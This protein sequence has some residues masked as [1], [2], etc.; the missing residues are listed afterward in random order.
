MWPR[1]LLRMARWARRPPSM[2]RVVLGAAVIA[3]CLLLAAAE[4]AGW[5]PSGSGTPPLKMPAIRPLP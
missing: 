4:W 5:L 2:Q 3:L 1:L